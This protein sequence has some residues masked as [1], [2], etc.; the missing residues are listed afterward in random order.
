MITATVTVTTTSTSLF[1]LINT[2][3]PNK[4]TPSKFN[5]RV[6]EVQVH[7][8]TGV[9]HLFDMPGVVDTPPG[10]SVAANSGYEFATAGTATAEQL[11]VLRQGGINALNLNDIYLGAPPAGAGTARIT[12]YSI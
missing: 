9:F 4:F 7:W 3:I 11:L 1:D 2:A 5:G 10:P 6:A 12:A 8:L